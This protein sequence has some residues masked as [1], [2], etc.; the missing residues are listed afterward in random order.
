MTDPFSDHYWIEEF[1]VT[2]ADLDRITAHIRET[3]RAHDLTTL[4]RR[5]VRGRL[6]YGPETSTPALAGW[7]KDLSVRLWDP[8]GEW[9]QTR[10]PTQ[11][12]PR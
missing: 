8:A 12:S 10:R 2:K 3:S 4:A 9:R 7:A 6:R 5:V 1:Q 11:P